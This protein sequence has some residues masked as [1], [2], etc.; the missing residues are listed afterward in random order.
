[1]SALITTETFHEIPVRIVQ[2]ENCPMIPLVDVAKGLGYNTQ[3]ITR[4]YERNEE[5]LKKYSQTAI[6]TTGDQV[7][8]VSL[9]C[10]SRD[11]IVGL[12]MK[13]DYRRTKNPEKKAAI[14]AF[15]DWAIETLGKVM[16][17]KLSPD[18]APVAMVLEDQM[19]IARVMIGEGVESGIARAMAFSVTEEITHCGDTLTPWKNLV[20]TDPFLE[21][22]AVLNPTDIGI[23]LGGMTARTV[24]QLLVRFGYQK[25]IGSE[26]VPTQI[27]K[28]YARFVP[29]EIQHNH[30]IVRHMQLKWLPG[31]IEKIREKMYYEKQ[32]QA[33]LF[34]GEC[35]S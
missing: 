35:G 23:D 12:T 31:I 2:G 15:Q 10:L 32:G 11:G 9:V 30:G 22:S 26:W 1:M 34:L 27:G 29:Q 13:L 24:N 16:D 6:M 21:E 33:G 19:A 5:L 8:P 28:V 7:A 20:H 25:K 3:T 18:Y 4:L 14:L 17:G